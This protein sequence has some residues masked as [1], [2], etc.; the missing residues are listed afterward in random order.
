MSVHG[1]KNRRKS[2]VKRI[3]LKKK[4]NYPLKIP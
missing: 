4:E 1:K 2:V 3:G